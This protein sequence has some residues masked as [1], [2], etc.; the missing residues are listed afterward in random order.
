M[1]DF[2]GLRDIDVYNLFDACVRKVMGMEEPKKPKEEPIKEVK[3]LKG[4]KKVIKKE[5]KRKK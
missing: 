1:Q 2:T 3:E 4:T 5:I